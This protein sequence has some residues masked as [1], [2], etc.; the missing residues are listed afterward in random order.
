MRNVVSKIYFAKSETIFR[1]QLFKQKS[2]HLRKDNQLHSIVA[3]P[4]NSYPYETLFFLNTLPISNSQTSV[5]TSIQAI[6]GLHII[7]N[8]QVS[9][10]D[11]LTDF[12][13]FKNFIDD[14]IQH[15]SLTC[16]GEVYHNFEGG[17][18]TGVACLT[19]SHLSIHT[20]PEHH[21]I[22]F[23]V[24]LSN[25]LKDN[26]KTTESIYSDVVDFF[27][28]SVILEQIIDR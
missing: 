19:E 25:H 22:T 17:G 27:Q 18:F 5:A 9:N 26:R 15:Y 7:A 24:F 3:L 6:P 14:R 28:A 11:K 2:K 12:L 1:N 10:S 21:Y 16:V 8:L 4:K 23:D 20:W 13:F